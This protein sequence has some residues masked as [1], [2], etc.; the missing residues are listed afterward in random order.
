MLAYLFHLLF[1][2][3]FMSAVQK[4]AVPAVEASTIPSAISNV[5]LNP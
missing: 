3:P 2:K 5:A 1:E 4:Q